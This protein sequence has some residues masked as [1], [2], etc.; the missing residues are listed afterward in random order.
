M[1]DDKAIGQMIGIACR[2]FT[3]LILALAIVDRKDIALRMAPHIQGMAAI[4]TELMGD[5]ELDQAFAALRNAF[6]KMKKE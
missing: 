4:A 5:P 3:P 6:E 2:E 1:S